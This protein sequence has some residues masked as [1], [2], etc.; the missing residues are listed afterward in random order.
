[1]RTLKILTLLSIVALSVTAQTERGSIT[2]LVTDPTGAAVAGAELTLV[3]RDTNATVKATATNSG[4]FSLPN[5]LPGNYRVDITAA[6]FKRFVRQNIIIS[7][8]STARGSSTRATTS[9]RSVRNSG[10]EKSRY[11]R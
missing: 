3:N 7:A 9:I 4:E 5:L 6:G 1:M 8:A 11:R 10:F 2:G